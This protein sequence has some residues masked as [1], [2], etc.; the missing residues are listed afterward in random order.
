MFAADRA[1]HERDIPV[2]SEPDL[3]RVPLRTSGIT[4]NFGVLSYNSMSLGRQTMIT[5]PP[6]PARC[7]RDSLFGGRAI[8]SESRRRG[9]AGTSDGVF[10]DFRDAAVVG[11]VGTLHGVS[12]SRILS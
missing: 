7:G 1:D 6:N 4:E 3:E 10:V 12:G 11:A 8:A 2:Q 9:R 5:R